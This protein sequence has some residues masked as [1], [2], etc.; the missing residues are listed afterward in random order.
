L[1]RIPGVGRKTAERLVLE[2]REVARSMVE[3]GDSER[4]ATL[5]HAEQD[6]IGAL[7]GLGYKASEVDRVA[8][9]VRREHPNAAFGELL[10]L[11]LRSL[12]RV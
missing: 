5:P 1:Q 11:A 9:T 6:L 12:S 8:A 3:A 7:L 10:R 4:P 2:L